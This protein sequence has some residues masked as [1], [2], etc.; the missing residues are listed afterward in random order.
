MFTPVDHPNL[1]LSTLRKLIA[2]FNAASRFRDSPRH[3]MAIT[4][5]RY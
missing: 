3:S 4:A 1:E 5:T 2:K